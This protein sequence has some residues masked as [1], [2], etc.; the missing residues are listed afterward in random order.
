MNECATYADTIVNIVWIVG[1]VSTIL[2]IA[3]NT[4]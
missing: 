2:A 4:K 3:W 1:I